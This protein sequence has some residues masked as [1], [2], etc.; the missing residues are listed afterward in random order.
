MHLSLSFATSAMI[1]LEYIR[2]FSLWPLGRHLD[3]FLCQ[4]TDSKDSGPAILSHFYLILGC[5]LPIWL[6][7]FNPKNF[8]F[9]G[10]SGIVTIGIGDS[11]VF[12][13]LNPLGLYCW[14]KIRI[15]QMAEFFKN[16][17]R[18]IGLHM[19]LSGMFR[20]PFLLVSFSAV[21]SRRRKT[22]HRF[23]SNGIN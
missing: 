22:A 18:I 12:A 19:Q 5:A 16:N 1:M 20:C 9:A 3:S 21:S 8:G 15:S 23:N 7:V 11:L 10:V 13:F 17:R 14:A 6:S 4:F 2:Y